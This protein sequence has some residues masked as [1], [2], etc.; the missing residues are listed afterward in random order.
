MIKCYKAVRKKE[1]TSHVT[2][3]DLE[4]ILLSETYQRKTNII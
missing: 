4:S 3:M 2:W 1:I